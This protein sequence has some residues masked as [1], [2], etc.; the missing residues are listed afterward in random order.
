M[1][2]GHLF[3]YQ[4]WLALPLST[5]HKLAEKYGVARTRPI[6]VVNNEVSD[7][8]YDLKQLTTAFS[9]SKLEAYLAPASDMTYQELWDAMISEIE[10][11][12]Y[13]VA[14]DVVLTP[15]IYVKKQLVVE[16]PEGKLM[17]NKIQ[18]WFLKRKKLLET[19][20]EV[21]SEL[22]DG[23]ILKPKNVKKETGEE[24]SK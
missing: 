5:R 24:G 20:Y 14:K 3:S 21:E 2:H 7:D 22:P 1:N 23:F 18:G 19:G 6:H 10:G 13:E 15:P 9:L 12:V 4:L 8:G 17:L 16:L 11:K